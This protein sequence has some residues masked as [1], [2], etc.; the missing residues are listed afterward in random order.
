MT[1]RCCCLYAENCKRLT[2][3]P[4]GIAELSALTKLDAFGCEALLSLPQHLGQLS[5]LQELDVT[6]CASLQRLPDSIGELHTNYHSRLASIG[7]LRI[8]I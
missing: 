4:E 6:H 1:C 2:A 7:E 8:H 3:L 5:A